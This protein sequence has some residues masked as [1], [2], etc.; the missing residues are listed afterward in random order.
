MSVKVFGY[1]EFLNSNLE[2]N[3]LVKMSFLMTSIATQNRIGIKLGGNVSLVFEERL[4][5]LNKLTITFELTDDPLDINAEVLFSGEGVAN[6]VQ[7][8]RIDLGETLS[9]R[10]TRVQKFLYEL[11]K[12]KNVSNII[13]DIN[14]E[15]GDEFETINI[16]VDNFCTKML[17][18]YK[19]EENWTPSVRIILS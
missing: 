18:L 12:S 4:K 3:D 2:I 19:Q 17:E 1:L 10:M 7:G 13:L 9:S 14:I 15:E 5:D 16:S 6:Y 11:L 8:S